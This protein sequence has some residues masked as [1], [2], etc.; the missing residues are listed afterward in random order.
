MRGLDAK[1]LNHMATE[2]RIKTEF[3]LSGYGQKRTDYWWD[4]YRQLSFIRPVKKE[5]LL[6]QD[7]HGSQL[8]T[9]IFWVDSGAWAE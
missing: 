4:F 2:D 9:S 3:I 6:L 5:G 7:E 1:L 8:Y